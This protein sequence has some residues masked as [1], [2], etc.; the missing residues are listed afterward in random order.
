MTW[1]TE[2][3]TEPGWYWLKTADKIMICKIYL[4]LEFSDKVLLIQ[5]FGYDE[6]LLPSA[7][8]LAHQFQPVKPPE[9][10]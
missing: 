9:E 10:T 3:P 8:S 1:T 6:E 2:L 4:D 5:A 7:P